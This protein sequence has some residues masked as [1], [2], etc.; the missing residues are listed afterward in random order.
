MFIK[1]KNN[2]NHEKIKKVKELKKD[3]FPKHHEEHKYWR[4]NDKQH[5]IVLEDI[6]VYNDRNNIN[7]DQT[8]NNDNS[9]LSPNLKSEYNDQL[10]SD[11][12]END[13]ILTIKNNNHN[14]EI[15]Y[16]S[17]KKIKVQSI[18]KILIMKMIWIQ[19]WK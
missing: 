9:N 14:K 13:K 7:E 6:V 5:V 11:N 19:R 3:G 17:K 2:Y 10:N 4:I 8:E 18:K 15:K 16:I 1:K 12:K